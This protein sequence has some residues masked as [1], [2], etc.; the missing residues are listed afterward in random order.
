ME[1]GRVLHELVE[2]Q[3]REL[4]LEDGLRGVEP[5][6]DPALPAVD[7][8]RQRRTDPGRGDTDDRIHREQRDN[9]RDLRERERVRVTP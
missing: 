7:G 2:Q 5:Q 1:R 4:D 9:Q 6:L 8:E 3:Q